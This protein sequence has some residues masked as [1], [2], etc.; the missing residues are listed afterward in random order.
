MPGTG[1]TIRARRL[2]QRLRDLR[3]TAGLGAEEAARRL[4]WSRAKLVRFETATAVPRPADAGALCDLYGAAS[5]ERALLIQ[6]A[7]A[8][9]PA[10]AV[11]VTTV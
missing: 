9:G 3:E 10:T 8:A 4:G 11:A 6:L 7:G 1:P 2:G 5:D